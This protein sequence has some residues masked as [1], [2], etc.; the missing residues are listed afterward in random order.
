MYY[1]NRELAPLARGFF[2]KYKPRGKTRE[3]R[4]IK[5]NPKAKATEM[6]TKPNSRI[7]AK[8]MREVLEAE[9]FETLA[10][11]SEATKVRCARL[12]IPY[13][14]DAIT[15][16]MA[17]IGSNR[18]LTGTRP[19]VTRRAAVPESKPSEPVGPPLSRVEAERIYQRIISAAGKR[20]D[21][22]QS[23]GVLAAARVPKRREAS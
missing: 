19:V 7:I 11:L 3:Y 16:A 14:A 12:R 2:F 15:H 4:Q 23:V 21:G 1:G 18:S 6:P 13:T 9:A 22:W 20:G 10:D 17:L 5:E 8:V